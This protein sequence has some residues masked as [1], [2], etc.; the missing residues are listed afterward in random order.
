MAREKVNKTSSYFRHY[1][2][3]MVGTVTATEFRQLFYC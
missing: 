2:R 3:N 1:F